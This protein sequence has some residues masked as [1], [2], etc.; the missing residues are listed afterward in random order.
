MRW[1]IDSGHSVVEF[2]VRHL[3][4]ST[5]KGRFG[6]FA[7]SIDTDER[8]TPKALEVVIDATSIDTNHPD[9]DQHLRSAD[10]FD[11][12]RHPT[13]TFR[14]TSVKRGQ[15]N[16]CEIEGQLTM[17]GVTRPVTFRAVVQD[18]VKDPWG[19]RRIAGV[20]TG[21][22]NRKE[23]GLTWNQVL[24]TGAWLVGEDVRFN[25]EVEAVAAEA[26]QAVAV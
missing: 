16:S 6:R 15:D 26:T 21:K 20:G 5:V 3:G 10:F 17:H 1:N 22:L 2:G 23:W 14:S 13:I 19:N 7:G 4:I 8:G 9:R 18:S 11:T 24:E 12:E 25:L